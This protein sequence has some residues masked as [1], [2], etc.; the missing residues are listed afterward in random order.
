MVKTPTFSAVLLAAVLLAGCGTSSEGSRYEDQHGVSKDSGYPKGEP[1][2]SG[3]PA[4]ASSS[5]SG[6]SKEGP[7]TNHP[8]AEKQKDSEHLEKKQ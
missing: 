7:K 8:E 4:L 3:S 1:K 2:D 6:E 5:E